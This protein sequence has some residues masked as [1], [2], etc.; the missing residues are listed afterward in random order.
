MQIDYPANG[1]T[2]RSD[3]GIAGWALD[4]GS[5]SGTGV[6]LVHAWAFPTNGA[7][8][9]FIGGGMSISNDP[10]SATTSATRSSRPAGSE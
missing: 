2:I 1:S 4:L 6:S 9:I 3:F 8:P 10:T 5:T 7:T